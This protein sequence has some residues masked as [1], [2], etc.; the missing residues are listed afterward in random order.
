MVELSGKDDPFQHGFPNIVFI[1]PTIVVI[2]LSGK[3]F[4]FSFFFFSINCGVIQ[5]QL[6]VIPVMI[7]YVCRYV[8]NVSW[9]TNCDPVF[10]DSLR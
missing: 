3:L 5:E 7:C 2:G 1:V 8:C 4:Y 10:L 9:V 6:L